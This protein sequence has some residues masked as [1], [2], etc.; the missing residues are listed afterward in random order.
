MLAVIRA[1]NKTP[2]SNGSG[3]PTFVFWESI[4]SNAGNATEMRLII[5][6]VIENKN[7]DHETAE[8]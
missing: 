7:T 8:E 5:T 1:G 6:I 3:N 2:V 4:T